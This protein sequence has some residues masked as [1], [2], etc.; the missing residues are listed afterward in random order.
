MHARNG[1]HSDPG[2]ARPSPSRSRS[3]WSSADRRHR[4]VRRVLRQRERTQ[5]SRPAHQVFAAAADQQPMLP[6][7]IS[8][9]EQL[10]AAA[11]VK[12]RSFGAFAS[13]MA[14]PIRRVQCLTEAF[15]RRQR[16]GAATKPQSSRCCGSPAR[17]AAGAPAT[18]GAGA[19]PNHTIRRRRY[20]MANIVVRH[21]AWAL[22]RQRQAELCAF[23]GL[24]LALLI[25]AQHQRLLR[26]G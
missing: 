13:A 16:K 18:S 19:D 10:H 11:V 23:E 5:C 25:A 8:G 1:P 2:Q 3:Q 7:W 20:A 15:G 12:P 22:G 21:R 6:S 14:T 26:A 4:P 9:P 17:K 24:A